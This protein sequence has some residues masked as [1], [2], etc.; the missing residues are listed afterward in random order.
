ML[1]RLYPWCR[2]HNPLC[3]G[4]RAAG[5]VFEDRGESASRGGRRESR[6]SPCSLRFARIDQLDAEA[7]RGGRRGARLSL[8]QHARSASL[9]AQRSLRRS[10]RVA[11]MRC[12][13]LR[14]ARRARSSTSS[15]AARTQCW[16]GVGEARTWLCSTSSVTEQRSSCWCSRSDVARR[17][18]PILWCSSIAKE[19]HRRPNDQGLSLA[20]KVKRRAIACAP[21]HANGEW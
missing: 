13:E 8:Q 12:S 19:R 14:R 20:M 21:E 7:R 17:V 11:L 5:A 3:G 10:S 9:E 16:W 4:M 1:L 18:S 6:K 15:G 2:L